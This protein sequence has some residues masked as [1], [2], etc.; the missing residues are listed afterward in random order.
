[1]KEASHGNTSLFGVMF[2]NR[3]VQSK[4]HRVPYKTEQTGPGTAVYRPFCRQLA[5]MLPARL[6]LLLLWLVLLYHGIQA[7]G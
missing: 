7:Q 6:Q 1:M 5:I 4:Q 3:K 2:A